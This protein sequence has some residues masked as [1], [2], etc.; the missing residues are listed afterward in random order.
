VFNQD[1]ARGMVALC[2]T[3]HPSELFYNLG[4]G[5]GHSPA[6]LI[7]LI[8]TLTGKRIPVNIVDSVDQAA[9]SGIEAYA[10]VLAVSAALRD[11]Q[12]AAEYDLAAGFAKT[13][14]MERVRR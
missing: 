11:L 10:G 7:D 1:V 4:T 12:W 8:E 3:A 14:E 2:T 6:E 5:V 9:A 13:L